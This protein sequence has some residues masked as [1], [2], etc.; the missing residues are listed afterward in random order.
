MKHFGALISSV[1]WLLI[2][3]GPKTNES[4]VCD[5]RKIYFFYQ[6]SC[7][8]CH[9]AAKYIKN[10]YPLLEIEALDVQQKKNFALLQKAAEKYQISER[11]GTPL[12]CFGNE[13]I[14]GWSEKNKRLFDVFVQPFLAE[15]IE[16][17]N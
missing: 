14:M 5:G 11:I 2:G 10:K 15:K 12:I 6:T 4:E 17:Q 16:K 7:S 3:C 1:C 13:Y 9:D 8:H